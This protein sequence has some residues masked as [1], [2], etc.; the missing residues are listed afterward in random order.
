MIKTL[1]RFDDAA[2]I[3]EIRVR[4]EQDGCDGFTDAF[5]ALSAGTWTFFA[6]AATSSSS[7]V[8]TMSI[9][10]ITC[11]TTSTATV[12]LEYDFM[13]NALAAAGI[14]ATVSGLAGFFLVMRGQTFASHALSHVGVGATGAGLLGIAPLW[15]LVAFTRAVGLG[16]GFLDVRISM[17]T[18]PSA[19]S[20]PR[21][22]KSFLSS[23]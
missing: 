19:S 3:T 18:S 14:V 21:S 9:A 22:S 8:E 6:P 12:M 5:R 10:S 16:M 7:H 15:G 20:A 11:T 17:A 2:V 23:R 13:I 1:G 4:F